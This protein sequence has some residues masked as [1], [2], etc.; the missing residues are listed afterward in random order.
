MS[1]T[2]REYLP[3]LLGENFCQKA[4]KRRVTTFLTRAL[5]H[6]NLPFSA[7]SRYV[8]TTLLLSFLPD[9]VLARPLW[10][11]RSTWGRVTSKRKISREASLPLVVASAHSSHAARFQRREEWNGR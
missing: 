4:R 7:S 3:L 11:R 1:A 8:P 9:L 6:E 5:P 10:S 2:P